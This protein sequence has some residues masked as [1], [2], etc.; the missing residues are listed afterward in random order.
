MHAVSS[1]EVRDIRRFDVKTPIAF[2][3]NGIDEALLKRHAPEPDEASAWVY[4]GRLAIDHKGLDLLVEGYALLH[5]TQGG[6]LPPLVLAGPDF[7]GGK[8]RIEQLARSLDITDSIIF[9]GPVFGEDK[10][11]LLSQARLFVHTSRWEGM[12]F[13]VLEGLALGRPVLVTPQTNLASYVEDYRAGWVVEGTPETIAGGLRTVLEAPPKDL[14]AVGDRAR[15][16]A[17]DNFSW[18]SVAH[19]MA[20]IYNEIAR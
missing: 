11:S 2:V 16:L 13:A 5:K 4:I 19:Q 6:N 8:K 17:R 3:P 15:S 14:N 7:R 9:K 10:W 18:P 12:P 1:P 20:E